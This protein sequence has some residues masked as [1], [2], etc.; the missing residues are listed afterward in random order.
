MDFAIAVD[1][2]AP[3][4]VVWSVMRDGERWPEWTPSVTSVEIL[5]PGPLAVGS[6]ARI[7]Q[8]RFPPAMWT[9]TEVQ[10]RSFTWVSRSPG[11]LVTARHWVE[12]AALGARAHLS[13]NFAG[14]FGPLLGWLT[15]NIN[16][17]Y[18]S[19]EAAGLKKRS[20]ELAAWR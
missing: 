10:D 14:L 15:R 6:R 18:L 16:Q 20:E 19:L 11:V 2:N 4:D 13:L 7:R 3:P 12:P 5:T 17:R 1:V 9:V 8:P